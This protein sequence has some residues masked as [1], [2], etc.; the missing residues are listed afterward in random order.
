MIAMVELSLWIYLAAVR[1]TELC[2]DR[3]LGR[4]PRLLHLRAFSASHFSILQ[5]WFFDPVATALG[6]GTRPLP[7]IQSVILSN[8]L[9]T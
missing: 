7:N 6:S 4:W 3:F 1:L 2:V 5:G 8:H 9:H